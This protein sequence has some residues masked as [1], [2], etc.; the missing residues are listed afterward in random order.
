M[1]TKQNE[2]LTFI[3][4]ENVTWGD[5]KNANIPIMKNQNKPKENQTLDKHWRSINMHYHKE[6]GQVIMT[7]MLPHSPLLRTVSTNLE[8]GEILWTFVP[9]VWERAGLESDEEWSTQPSHHKCRHWAQSRKWA[10]QF[11]DSMAHWRYMGG[12]LSHRTIEQCRILDHEWLGSDQ[13]SR[14]DAD[15]VD[16]NFTR[17]PNHLHWTSWPLCDC[18]VVASVSLDAV[19]LFWTSQVGRVAVNEASFP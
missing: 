15:A 3:A 4:L 12:W 5:T 14:S 6:K 9:E 19:E 10:S 11:K 7:L 1:H 17:I 8:V 13:G 18:H 2:T 16:W